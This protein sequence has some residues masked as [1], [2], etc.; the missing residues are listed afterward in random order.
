MAGLWGLVVTAQQFFSQGSQVVG[1][2]SSPAALQ[3][4]LQAWARVC[5][6]LLACLMMSSVILSS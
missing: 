1:P 4:L 5:E 6:H 3:A 2:A